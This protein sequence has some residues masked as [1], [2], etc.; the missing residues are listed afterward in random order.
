MDIQEPSGNWLIEFGQSQSAQQLALLGYLNRLS[1]TERTEL[2]GELY[3]EKEMRIK[4]QMLIGENDNWY[5]PDG[6]RFTR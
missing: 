5:D 1:P 6:E 4:E 3:A 2:L